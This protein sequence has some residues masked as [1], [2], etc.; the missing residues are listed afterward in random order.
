LALKRDH[1]N[2]L[3]LATCQMLFGTGRSLFIVASPVVSLAIAPHLALA[4][5][6]TALIIVGTALAAMPSSML[7][8]RVGRKAGFLCGTMLG[9]ASGAACTVA[10]FTED[11]WLLALG[12]LL[13]V[14]IVG[15][16]RGGSD[17]S[18]ANEQSYDQHRKY[19]AIHVVSF[20]KKIFRGAASIAGRSVVAIYCSAPETFLFMHGSSA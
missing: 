20:Q 16:R 15:V 19:G 13:C 14:R 12:G 9:M 8:Q 4:T 1:K 3:V 10:V 18:R 11:F 2:V 6:P 17:S 5:L 7:T